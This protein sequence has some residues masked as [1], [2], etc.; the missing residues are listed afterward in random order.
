V[1]ETLCATIRGRVQGV[2]YRYFVVDRA[3]ELGLVGWARNA[4]DGA[5]EVEAQGPRE[6]LERLAD[7]LAGGPRMAHVTGLTV[8][9]AERPSYHGFEIRW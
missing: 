4:P 3:R 8:V 2:G 9:F 1:T 5:V 7:E 6:S